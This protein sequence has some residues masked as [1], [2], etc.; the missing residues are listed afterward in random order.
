MNQV[1]SIFVGECGNQIGNEYWK[2]VAQ[3]HG[4]DTNG[5]YRGDQDNQLDNIHILFDTQSSE[6]HVARSIHVDL[7]PTT[8]ENIKKSEYGSLLEP[9]NMTKGKKGTHNN[10]AKGYITDGK[11]II[12]RIMDNVRKETE[13][14]EDFIGFQLVYSLSGGTGSGLGSLLLD[15]LCS[16]FPEKIMYN[17]IVSP[18]LK[19]IQQRPISIYNTVLS[20]HYLAENSNST[21]IYDNKKLHKICKEKLLIENPN[22]FDYNQIVSKHMSGISSS[23]R[24]PGKLNCDLRKICVN[25]VPFPRLHIFSPSMFPINCTTFHGDHKTKINQVYKSIFDESNFLNSIDPKEGKFLASQ[26]IFEGVKNMN[27]VEEELSQLPNNNNNFNKW[28]N[29]PINIAYNKKNPFQ[30]S[31]SVYNLLNTTSIT[32][33]LNEY[34]NLFTTNFKKSLSMRPLISEGLTDGEC[35]EARS[36]LKDLIHDYQICTN[37]DINFSMSDEEEE[38]E[39]EIDEEYEKDDDDEDDDEEEDDEYEEDD[40]EEDD[41][42]EEEYGDENDDYEEGQYEEQDD[43]DD[44]DEEENE[45]HEE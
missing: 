7:D 5:I 14:C 3:E 12:E 41:D 33:G 40:D 42:E 22:F 2:L 45:E 43:E 25:L 31:F 19:E 28:M 34:L 4:L 8:I 11:D 6:K 26:S 10:F 18:S 24:F 30:K 20:L 15:S 36:N 13:K 29:N 39:A 9:Q 21:V 1:I 32:I 37:T 27:L 17:Y 16:E 35:S 44:D 38:E 23:M